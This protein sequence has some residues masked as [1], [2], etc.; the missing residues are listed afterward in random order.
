MLT[1][2][3]QK[4]SNK[5]VFKPPLTAILTNGHRKEQATSSTRSAAMG[6]GVGVKLMATGRRPKVMEKS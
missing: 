5:N 2:K 3:T 4:K 1:M 6:C